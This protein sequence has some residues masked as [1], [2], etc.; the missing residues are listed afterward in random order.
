MWIV[1]SLDQVKAP[2]FVALGNFDGIHRGHR[3]VIQ[4]ILGTTYATVV[5]FHP[6]PQ[7]FFTGQRRDLL[8]PIAEKSRHLAELGVQQLVLLPFNRELADLTPEAFVAEILVQQLQ[9][10]QISVGQDFC[11]GRQRSGTTADLQS[12][13]ATHGIPVQ[14][15]PLHT[16]QGERISSSAI[17][18][19]LSEGNLERA[20]QLLGRPYSLIGQVIQGQQLG[21]TIG[22]PTANLQLPPE[23]FLP[24]QGVYSVWVYRLDSAQR[25]LPGVMN[26]GNRPTVDGAKLSVE[27]HLL[28]W[29][30][31]LYGETLMVNLEGFLRAE[32]KFASLDDLKAQ[33]QRDCDVARSRL[34]VT[35]LSTNG[36]SIL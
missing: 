33:I 10:Q 32:Q 36:R 8:T 2:T 15:A 24:R 27:V 14:I 21:R 1:D 7:E 17:R 34:T 20:N 9:A 16:C 30:E 18:H 22:F 6:H 35:P 11:F 4:P 19:A 28:D 3:Q 13:A 12:I 31:N 23:K 25:P 29:S 5:T 26:L